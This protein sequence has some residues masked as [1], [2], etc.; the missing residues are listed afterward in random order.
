MDWN[1]ISG[2]CNN[3]HETTAR[4]VDTLKLI[5]NKHAPLKRVSRNKQKQLRKPW[6]SKGM[7]KSIKTKHA[8][9]K[10]HYLSNDPVTINEFKKLKNLNNDLFILEHVYSA[11]FRYSY[12]I[13]SSK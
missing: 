6:I 8:M 3:L 12:S 1:A 5:V 13:V 4:T 10:T 2:K 9:Y 11:Y 7:L